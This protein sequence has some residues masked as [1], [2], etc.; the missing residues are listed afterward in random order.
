MFNWVQ[1]ESLFSQIGVYG[2][3]NLDVGTTTKLASAQLVELVTRQQQR[4]SLAGKEKKVENIAAT[5]ASAQYSLPIGPFTI[6]GAQNTPID[7]FYGVRKRRSEDFEP[8]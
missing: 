4:G 8:L 3:A 7:N 1:R 6:L 2:S 5:A